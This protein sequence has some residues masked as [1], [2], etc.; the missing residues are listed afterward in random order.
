L[1]LQYYW[2]CRPFV[3]GPDSDSIVWHAYCNRVEYPESPGQRKETTVAKELVGKF[4]FTVP[5]GHAESGKTIEKPFTFVEVE[6]DAEADKILADKKLSRKEL[7]NDWLKKNA[8]SNAY[9]AATLVY[10]PSEVPVEDIYERMRRDAIR[11][12]QSEEQANV[13][14]ETLKAAA[15]ANQAKPAEPVTE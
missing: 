5:E 7:V 13:F 14:I 6:T 15:A 1:S 12:G 8:R 10:R 9:Q 3:F 11:T 4:S 2:A